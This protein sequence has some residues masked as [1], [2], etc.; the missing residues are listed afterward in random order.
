MANEL[1]WDGKHYLVNDITGQKFNMLL[2][3]EEDHYVESIKGVLWWFLCDC[4]KHRLYRPADVLSG[5]KRSCG[6]WRDNAKY[7]PSAFRDH[8]QYGRI[9]GIYMGMRQRCLNPKTT[10]YR[11]YGGR[12]ISICAE[13]MADRDVFFKW[14]FENGYAADLTIDRWPNNDGNYEP[15]NCRWVTQKLN[16]NNTRRTVWLECN[17]ERLSLSQWA[18]RIGIDPDWIARRVKAGWPVEHA[19]G[20]FEDEDLSPPINR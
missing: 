3:L 8:S 16:S 19:L 11:N 2:A 17:G 7:H 1:N 15:S 10:N 9:N 18:E 5:K 13:W 20:F 6:C 4:G 14:S 12:G